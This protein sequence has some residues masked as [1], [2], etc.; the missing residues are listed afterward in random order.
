MNNLQRFSLLVLILLVAV[1]M[2]GPL[3]ISRFDYQRRGVVI[4]PGVPGDVALRNYDENPFKSVAEP[5]SPLDDALSWLLTCRLDTGAVDIVFVIDSSGSMSGTITNVRA[6]IGGLIS[7]LDGAGYDY[8]LGGITYGD[9]RNIWDFDLSTPGNQM[10][11]NATLFT[12]GTW[13]GGVGASGGADGPEQS[14]DAIADAINRYIW[15]PDALHIVIGFT[16]ASYCQVGDGCTGYCNP[17]QGPFAMPAAQ[18]DVGVAALIASTGTVVFWASPASVYSGSCESFTSPVPWSPYGG[19]GHNGWYQYFCHLS[20]GKWYNLSTTSWATIFADVAALINTYEAVMIDVTNTTGGLINPVTAFINPGACISILSSNP[21]SA[22]IAAGASHRFQWQVDYDGT[23]S[24]SDL[25]FTITVS[26]GGHADTAFGCIYMEDCQCA[27]P[28]PV[29]ITPS[30]CGIWTACEYQEIVIELTD[31]D[32]GTNPY[33]IQLMVDS[34]LYSYPTFMTW[35]P[36]S[37]T[38]GRLTFTPPTPWVH[39][40]CV[41]WWIVRADD[42][43]GCRVAGNGY[44]SFCV[45]LE[46]PAEIDWTPLCGTIL[47]DTMVFIDIGIED[48]ESGINIL[49]LYFTVNGTAF[50]LGAGP[51]AVNWTGTTSTGRVSISGSINQ[52]GLGSADSAVV[53]LHTCDRVTSTWCGPNCAEYCCVFY[54]NQPPMAEFVYPDEGTWTACDP[55]LISLHIWDDLGAAINPSTVILVINGYGYSEADPWLTVTSDSIL[56]S[57]PAGTFFDG[58]TIRACLVALADYAG[59]ACESLPI[60]RTFFLDYTPPVIFNVFP[61]ADTTL[62]SLPDSARFCI[63]DSLS[64]LNPFAF[65]YIVQDGFFGGTIVSDEV[66]CFSVALNDSMCISYGEL[67]TISICVYAEDMPDYCDA[68]VLDTCWQFYLHRTGPV[69]SIVFPQPNTWTACTDSGIII[70]IN[71]VMGPVDSTTIVLRVERM[72]LPPSIYRCSHADLMWLES[73]NLLWFHP[74]ESFWRDGDTIYVCLDSVSDVYGTPSAAIPMCWTYYTDFSPPVFWDIWPPMDTLMADAAPDMHVY[75]YDSLS[76]VSPLEIFA[77][78][79]VNSAEPDTYWISGG[80]RWDEATGLFE[81]I[82]SM[83]GIAFADSDSV[84]ICVYAFDT[85]DYCGPNWG[86]TCWSFVISLS[87]PVPQW[88]QYFPGA[89]VACDSFEQF[90]VMTIIDPDGVDPTSILITVNGDTFAVDSFQVSYV[91]DTLIF[92][93]ANPADFWHDNDSVVICLIQA[94]DSLGNPFSGPYCW[95][96]KM[97]LTPPVFWGEGP[98][99]GELL[100]DSTAPISV[101]LWDSLTGIDPSCVELVVYDTLVIS[102]GYPG[103]TYDTSLGMV[104]FNPA[105]SG[106]FWQDWDTVRVCIRACDSPDYC[107]PNTSEFC[108]EF[109]VHLLGPQA[110]IVTPQPGEITSCYDQCIVMNLW[111]DDV[112]VDPTTIELVVNGVTYTV[113]GTI[114]TFE[115]TPTETTLTFCPIPAGI[116][117]TDSQ[118]VCV[119]LITADDTLGNPLQTPLDWCFWVDLLPPVVEN[120]T[121]GAGS[122]CGDTIFTTRP[123]IRFALW[124]NLSGVDT[125]RLEITIDD[126]LAYHWGDPGITAVGGIF[127]V[128]TASLAPAPFYTGGDS[129]KICVF[130][131]DTTD[132]CADNNAV[133]CCKFYIMPGGPSPDWIRPLPNTWSACIDTEHVYCSIYDDD[134][135]V[136][137]SIIVTITRSPSSPAPGLTTLYYDSPG[138]TWAEPYFRYDPAVSFADPETV[139]VCIVQAWDPVLNPMSPDTLCWTFMMDQTPPAL[140]GE[141]PIDGAI[142]ATRHPVVEFDVVDIQSGLDHVSVGMSVTGSIVGAHSFPLGHPSIDTTYIA[143]GV[144]VVW[145]PDVAGI[146]FKGGEHVEVCVYAYDKPNYCTFN[147]LDQCWSFSIET[148]GPFAEIMRVWPDSISSCDPE[149]VLIHLWDDNGI[150][151]STIQL[152]VNGVVYHYPDRMSY[153][154]STEVLEYFPAPPFAPVDIIHVRLLA[155]EDSLG[156]P[157]DTT[158]YLD[159]T[160]YV[161]RVPPEVLS[162][163]PEGDIHATVPIFTIQVHDTL[164]GVNPDSIVVDVGGREFRV[165]DPGIS[166]APAGL[167]GTITLNPASAIPPMRWYGGDTVE[168]CVRLFDLADDY[169]VPDGCEPNYFDTCLAFQVVPGGPVGVI[170]NPNEGYYVACDPFV[171]NMRLTDTEDDALIEDSIRVVIA[172]SSWGLDD[173]IVFTLDSTELT[174]DPVTGGMVYNPIPAFVDGETVYIAIVAAM[175]TLFNGLEEGDEVTFYMDFSPP[176]ITGISPVPSSMISEIQP[177]IIVGLHDDMS[178][179]NP[180]SVILTVDGVDYTIASAGV[181]W[182]PVTEQITLDP[183]DI[184]LRWWG[185]DTVDVCIYAFDSPDTCGPNEMDS[186]WRFFIAPGGPVATSI[187]PADSAI[188]ACHPEFIELTI[189]DPDGI[190]DTTVVVSVYRSGPSGP[191]PVTIY[192]IGDAGVTWIEPTLRI[193]PLVLFADAETIRV[194][195]DSAADPIGNQLTNPHCWDFFMDLSVYA[196]WGM[197]PLDGSTVHTRRPIIEFSVWDTISG[198]DT[199][200]FRIT[201]DGINVFG[202]N[203][204]P[205]VNYDPLTGHVTMAASDCGLIWTGGDWVTVEIWGED[206]PT[207]CDPN[208]TTYTWTFLV[209]PGGPEAELINPQPWWYCSCDP[210]GIE[211]LLWDEDGVNESTIRLWVDGVEY[212]TDDPQLTY[213]PTDSLLFFDPDPNFING[214]VVLVELTEADDILGNELETPL[215]WSFIMDLQSPAISFTEPVAYMTRNRQQPISFSLS[216]NGSGIE[217]S[218]FELVIREHGNTHIY[219]YTQVDWNVVNTG[220]R[221]EIRAVNVTYYPNIHGIEFTSG[222]SVYVNVYLHDTPDTCAPN[223]YAD[224]MHFLIE[225]DVECLVFPNPFTPGGSPGIN[226]IAVFN[227]P[228]MFSEKAELVIYTVR[229][230]EVYRA[231]IDMVD[232]DIVEYGPRSWNGK[233]SKGNLLPDGLYIYLIIKGGEVVCNGTVVLAR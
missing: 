78:I 6:A 12:S 96:W 61:P 134:G 117:W 225:P 199:S 145:H 170:L 185:G 56:F 147:E 196:A 27:G 70:R 166:W 32:V 137:T 48:F 172:R 157:L 60:C 3:E 181:D 123:T 203:D 77:T 28:V 182:S 59:A 176:Y 86:D 30:P 231:D 58:D 120:F 151:D 136:D 75:L 88:V 227:Y 155:A 79:S 7:A 76:G 20:G 1:S 74:D 55:P 130:V 15:R 149:Y 161:D 204:A 73:E 64:G 201:I 198:L 25:C 93:P 116:F 52:L 222:D 228:F 42:W 104:Y 9:G 206:M 107:G 112:G 220:P 65:H 165:G 57:P 99:D 34:V 183:S 95:W 110:I 50:S 111:D 39:G 122:E 156:N 51:P 146:H 109:Y 126:T 85:P 82:P 67:C 36:I 62:L 92:D 103:F 142:V 207:V 89:W 14:L 80:V 102:A 10:T 186:C 213:Y 41:D 153:N 216:D 169:L 38:V 23:C 194:C 105:A 16:D 24:G 2:A 81:I 211:I 233:D 178:G 217:Q 159:W 127:T 232:R 224:S 168:W 139:E 132:L 101:Y 141:T 21:V 54:L 119:Q 171:I 128:N 18:T 100:A 210:Q 154:H 106:L 184:G 91:N 26:G 83:T 135:V 121:A 17:G 40:T 47:E 175:D 118:E 43:N 71:E 192:R 33:S 205:C 190:D 230:I 202:L 22:P 179:L 114:L 97:D 223:E 143:N 229:N 49:S 98:Y 214:Q 113:D 46:P 44:C 31:D 8:M 11:S 158:G 63:Y 4:E 68:H 226:D 129:V 221:G 152:E 218:S 148:G 160:F 215:S 209:A 66:N 195:I 133:Y 84:T 197:L 189:V 140:S 191:P 138:V 124:D 167:F 87:G 53:C 173:T 37:T 35:T 200:S 125:S 174:Y 29:T 13:L 72:G 212:T 164:A 144:S 162:A 90:A 131:E 188:S 163:L 5:H 193:D 94:I 187:N 108:W 150:V 45:D 177:L 208:E 69:P 219:N 180:S 115:A 19:T